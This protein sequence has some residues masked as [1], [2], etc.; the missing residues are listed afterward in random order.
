M[1]QGNRTGRAPLNA[2]REPQLER[3]LTLPEVFKATGLKRAAIYRLMS[4]GQFPRQI[5]IMSKPG[6]KR[7]ISIWLEREVIAWQ[8]SFIERDRLAED[9]PAPSV[10]ARLSPEARQWAREALLRSRER[11]AAERLSQFHENEKSRA[12][13]PGNLHPSAR[14]RSKGVADHETANEKAVPT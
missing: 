1:P 3:F 12:P 2:P 13:V 11:R 6:A 4:A 10:P 9:D 14:H 5:R 7:F 8:R